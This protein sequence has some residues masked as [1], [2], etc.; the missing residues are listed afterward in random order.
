MLS[1]AAFN[2][3]LKILEEPPQSTL[4]IL[5]TTDL[6][7]IIDTVQSRCFQLFFSPIDSTV[8]SEHLRNVCQ[9]EAILFEDNALDLIVQE[10]E[11][12][13]RGSTT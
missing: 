1:K 4:F 6:H 7:K 2:A 5:A 13:A 3:L 8:L 11:G 10:S 12:S 9:A